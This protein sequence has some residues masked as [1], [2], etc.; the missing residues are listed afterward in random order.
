M[1]FSIGVYYFASKQPKTIEMIQ[2]N[3]H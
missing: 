2:K 3:E 1:T